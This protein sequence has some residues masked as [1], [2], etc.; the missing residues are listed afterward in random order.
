MRIEACHIGGVLQ[1]TVSDDGRGVDLQRLRHTLVERRL[2]PADTVE[3]L[4]DSEL[5]DF[6]FLPGFTLKD[7]VSEISGR[8]VGLDAVRD[9][10]KQVR[11]Q[12]R[13][14]TEPQSGV[15]FQLQ[16]PLT[17]SLVSA[18]IA[19]IG[20]EAYAF[21]LAQIVRAL[22]LP[23]DAVQ[24][25]AGRQHI[26]FAGRQIGLVS[27]AQVLGASAS[28]TG[29]DL[30]ILILGEGAELYGL[31]VDRFLGGG[32]LVVQPLDP[33]LGKVRDV[34]AAALTADG[35]TVLIIDVEDTIRS[36]ER[37]VEGHRLAS[38]EAEGGA[39]EQARKRILVVDD[40]LTVRE[41]Q[42]K[43]LDHHGYEVQ[44][45]V[46]GMDAWASVRDNRFDLV[47]T[48]VDMP[49]MDGIELVTMMRRDPRLEA[50]PVVIL[51]YKDRED[52]RRRGLAAGADYYLTKGTFHENGLLTAV[53]DLIGKA[54]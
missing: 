6:L 27:G 37:L 47:I 4:S 9:M 5:L 20:G 50:L 48:D 44:V 51:S 19:D 41:L 43:L 11:S 36:M 49:R 29:A 31:V 10:L 22:R 3:R 33:R 12:V 34:S 32:E 16:L 42:R 45:A 2:A 35:E 46:D 21:P 38:V 24:T 25:V 15:R 53:V 40:S 54:A 18:L 14:T 28:G 30:S 1:V 8:G 39:E 17:L 52:D 7:E 23:H 13:V 26:E